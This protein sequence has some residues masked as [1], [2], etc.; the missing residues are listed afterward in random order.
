MTDWSL[1]LARRDDA[2]HLP[3]IER[4]ASALFAQNPEL[5]GIDFSDVSSV[6]QHEALIAKGHSLV[7]SA[8][9]KI[10]GFLAAEPH[11]R[12]LHIC[13]M[14]VDANYQQMGIGAG[15]LRACMIDARNSGFSA[16][17]LT[18]FRDIPWNAAF[19]ARLGFAEVSD[20]DAHP[21]LAGEL[22]SEETNGLPRSLRCAM[23]YFID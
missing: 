17:T 2:A 23:I 14:S 11:R 8:D 19:Y 3:G 10:V 13:E 18:T 4:S 1:R 21:R 22:A 16:L 9:E 6:A 5:A 20:L 12:E 15:L 7:S